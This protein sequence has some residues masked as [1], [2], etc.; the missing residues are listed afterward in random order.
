MVR[1]AVHSIMSHLRPR[2]D[3]HVLESLAQRSDLC[4]LILV[5]LEHKRVLI[6]HAPGVPFQQQSLQPRT[7]PSDRARLPLLLL[8][9]RFKIKLAVPRPLCLPRALF[10]GKALL[11]FLPP[12][13]FLFLLCGGKWEWEDTIQWGMSTRMRR[14]H[15]SLPLPCRSLIWIYR[16]LTKS[17]RHSAWCLIHS[18]FLALYGLG[19]FRPRLWSWL[20]LSRCLCLGGACHRHCGIL[21]VQLLDEGTIACNLC[22]TLKF[23]VS[24]LFSIFT[25]NLSRNVLGGLGHLWVVMISVALPASRPVT[26]KSRH[27]NHNHKRSHP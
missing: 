24:D 4:R 14:T 6:C 3:L 21:K 23:A 2:D 27:C 8:H 17:R 5:P 25:S 7:K 16:R 22:F 10:R 20:G 1:R 19:W 18:P 13:S 26:R 9:K 12:L 11:L 15:F